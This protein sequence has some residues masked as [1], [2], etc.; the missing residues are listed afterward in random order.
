MKPTFHRRDYLTGFHKRKVAKIEEKR[1]RAKE[2]EHAEHLAERRQ[3]R[4]DL[5]RKAAENFKN[6]R[7][8]MGLEDLPSDDENGPTPRKR[9]EAAEEPESESEEEVEYSDEEQAA[10]VTITDDADEALGLVEQ[11]PKR[12]EIKAPISQPPPKDKKRKAA[13]PNTMVSS[14]YRSFE[15][16]AERRKMREVEN[17]RRRE[18][19]EM[20]KEKRRASRQGQRGKG[21]KRGKR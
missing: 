8:A 4:E 11:I 6:V 9:E 19:A 13:G 21:K 2:R 1:K 10:V 20:G 14:D 7:R 18:K 5:K 3:L 12:V 15:T 17:A 16:K